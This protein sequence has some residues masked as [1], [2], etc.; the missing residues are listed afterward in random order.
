LKQAFSARPEEVNSENN[1]ENLDEN[2]DSSYDKESSDSGY[3]KESN[4]S[5]YDNNS[6]NKSVAQE[7]LIK[8]KVGKVGEQKKLVEVVKERYMKK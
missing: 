5:G 2:S 7:T 6:G 8:K 1:G 4:N 3:D